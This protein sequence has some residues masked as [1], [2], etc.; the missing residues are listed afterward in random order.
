MFLII[1]GNESPFFSVKGQEAWKKK[2]SLD[3]KPLSPQVLKTLDLKRKGEVELHSNVSRTKH[4]MT[5][6][7]GG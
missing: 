7:E 2:L 1:K 4:A 5:Q 6:K 3:H